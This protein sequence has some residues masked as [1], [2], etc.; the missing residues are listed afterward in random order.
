MMCDSFK[1]QDG[2]HVLKLPAESRLTNLQGRTVIYDDLTEGIV[3]LQRS[4]LIFVYSP[5]LKHANESSVQSYSVKFTQIATVPISL[6]TDAPSTPIFQ[7]GPDVSD[8]QPIYRTI[9]TNSLLVDVIAPLGMG[10]NVLLIGRID[11][12]IAFCNALS[13]GIDGRVAGVKVLNVSTGDQTE[14][15]VG[16]A[17]RLWLDLHRTCSV[18]AWLSKRGTHAVVMAPQDMHRLETLWQFSNQCLLELGHLDRE[19]AILTLANNSEKRQFYA[20]ILQRV[21]QFSEVHG[22]GSLTILLGLHTP[23]A[24]ASSPA[25]DVYAEEHLS[26]FP[27]RVRERLRTLLGKGISLTRETLTK[28]KIPLPA[29]EVSDEALLQ[30]YVL[31]M[32]SLS[33]GQVVFSE[34]ASSAIAVEKSFTR[35]R[36]VPQRRREDGADQERGSRTMG[37]AALYP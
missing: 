37:T 36:A 24:A 3:I 13:Q 21:G 22:G 35:V 29:T 1:F 31:D 2:V 33:D 26:L 9:P 11:H 23:P 34:K 27:E 7:P 17:A 32:M 8:I 20:S 25:L 6:D 10:Q 30:R 19:T 4:P 15:V 18:G 28:L 14:G 5:Q 12:S 16:A